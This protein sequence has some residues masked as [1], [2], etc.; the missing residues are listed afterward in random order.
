MLGAGGAA[1]KTY[2]DDVFST[3]LYA[4]T[5]SAQNINNGID[6]AGKGGM[7]WIKARNGNL[8]HSILDTVRGKTKRLKTNSSDAESTT[9]GYIADFENNGFEAGTS[10]STSSTNY[11]AFSF[12]KAKG[13]FTIKK[14]TGTG[15]NQTLTHDLGCAPGCIIYKNLTDNAHW[16]VWHRGLS[17]SSDRALSLSDNWMED[18]DVGYFNDT[19]PTATHFT[20][21]NSNQS[22]GNGDEIIAYLFAGGESTADTARSVHFSGNKLSWS[23][24]DDFHLTGDFT[25]EY[26]VKPTTYSNKHI[27]A[28]GT[29]HSTNGHL[30]YFYDN[31]WY[32][33]TRTSGGS[34][35]DHIAAD[36][37]SIPLGVWAHCAVV[38]SGSTVSTYVNGNLTKSFTNSDDF[39]ASSNKEFYVG[40]S[41]SGDSA[42]ADISNF[43]LVKGTAVYT[44]SFRPPTAPLTN[45]TNTKLL[46][47]N[48]SSVTGSPVTPGTI[49]A[50]GTPTAKTDSPFDDPAAFK[51]GENE[52][53]NI[54]K[55]GNYQGL[56]AQQHVYLGFEPQWFFVKAAGTT[57]SWHL[58]DCMR[59]CNAPDADDKWFEFN[60]NGSETSGN[61]FRITPT[62][63]AFE[64]GNASSLNGN[65]VNFIYMAIRRPD[66]YVGKPVEDAT[67]V[68]AMTAG[69]GGSSAPNY[70]GG[71]IVDF[72]LT[73][74]IDSTG[75]F[76][77]GSR[78]TSTYYNV[79]NSDAIQGSASTWVYDYMDGYNTGTSGNDWMSW[80]WKRHA[81]L[82]V[83]TWDGYNPAGVRAIPHNL[84]KVPEMIWM[85]ARD[86]EGGWSVYHKGL[87]GGTN[88]EQ[89]KLKLSSNAAQTDTAGPWYDTAPN[90][91]H[92]VVGDDN[93]GNGTY[94]YLA[95]LFASVSGISKVG[96]Y[97]GNGTGQ[98]IT[99][100]F[101]PRFLMVK[102][103]NGIQS[104][105]I[106]DTTRGWGS[107]T[108]NYLQLNSNAAQA[109]HDFGAPTSTGF[110]LTASGDSYNYNGHNY[111]YYAHA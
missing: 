109:A 6:L 83:V 103:A 65:G 57:S 99:T 20:V 7:T 93:D 38:R 28:I 86:Y 43:R 1:T 5:G 24:S 91:T 27:Y 72:H 47:C 8:S 79:T 92:W 69:K 68:F 80:Q 33:Q 44:S 106:L 60:T 64:N 97:T 4:G 111:I 56:G 63:F 18:D 71:N 40:A 9:T 90:S 34:G 12:R 36:K 21:G 11:A 13:F 14:F 23:A 39:G 26:W 32:I 104:W 55:C 30:S 67:K 73:R 98:T 102:R 59:G 75:D 53:Q 81:G 46:C 19:D 107:G 41:H 22:N 3:H 108:D 105:M 96:Y 10:A 45:I 78:L 89:Y 61:Y 42:E 95:I 50:T 66:G 29:Y 100:G 31:K 48:N 77:L 76:Y 52:D 87:N 82:D 35:T 15:N 54:I 110:T 58:V 84:G 16:V 88:P 51:F 70:Q 85:K 74:D 62:G 49:T 2:M 101:Q 17:D 94:D 25:I 37:I